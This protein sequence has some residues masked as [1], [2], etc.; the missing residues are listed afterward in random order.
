MTFN[1][2]AKKDA[3]DRSI[4]ELWSEYCRLLIDTGRPGV[5][6]LLN[7]MQ[8]DNMP[9]GT[10]N[11]VNAPASTRYHGAYPGGLVEHSLNVYT[12]LCWFVSQ[13]NIL[14]DESE[15]L[16]SEES[17]QLLNSC[18]IVALLHDLCKAGFYTEEWR[19]QKVYSPNGSKEDPG[20]RFDWQVVRSY[21]VMDTHYFGHGAASLEIAQRFLGVNGL[22]EE[23]KYAIRYH[24]GDF[25]NERETGDIYN[26]YPMATMLHMADLA[27]TYLDERNCGSEIDDFWSHLNAFAR[28]SK[29]KQTNT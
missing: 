6:R 11:F 2:V 10:L 16:T 12:R 25:A 9:N 26:R 29:D 20:G 24:M 5:K 17:A 19:N 15:K 13:E 28:P 1:V 18:A 23:E 8:S 7:W 3:P 21:K 27:A 14:R 22:T 4:Q